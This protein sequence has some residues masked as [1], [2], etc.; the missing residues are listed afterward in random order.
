ME[1]FFDAVF[2]AVPDDEGLG[3]HLGGG[4]IGLETGDAKHP[5]DGV[6]G[7][8]IDPKR[9]LPGLHLGTTGRLSR[10][11]HRRALGLYDAREMFASEQISDVAFNG[12]R[13]AR[14]TSPR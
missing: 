13:L 14:A 1:R 8:L 12:G 4:G 2:S 11:G 6:M 7:R 3:R 5:L 10:K 9:D